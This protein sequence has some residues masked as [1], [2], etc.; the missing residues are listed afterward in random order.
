M[1][2]KKSTSLEKIKKLG[3]TCK[4]CGHCCT[5]GSGLLAEGD[6]KRIAKHM[7][8]SEKKLTDKYLQPISK[9][10]TPTHKPKTLKH[11]EKEHLPFGKCIFLGKNNLCKIHE[12]KPL[13]CELGICNEHGSDIDV[14]FN[15][16]HLVDPKNPESIRQWNVY[17]KSGG[18][19]IP[20]GELN[21]LIPDEKRLKKILE[22]DILR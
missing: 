15:L 11:K 8:I 21:D 17:L 2:I 13:Q 5:F 9:F 20:G 18:K 22:Y 16:N 4:Q 3:N 6:I 12:A 1:E 10:D 7:K 14:W 19:N